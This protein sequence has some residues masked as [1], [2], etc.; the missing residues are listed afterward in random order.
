MKT[1]LNGRE[2]SKVYRGKR[3][4]CCCGCA[5]TYND[6]DRA[7][8]RAVREIEAADEADIEVGSSYVAL[9]RDNRLLIVYFS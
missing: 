2:V 4:R 6:S 1:T 3:D 7:K 8:A 5:G 9:A